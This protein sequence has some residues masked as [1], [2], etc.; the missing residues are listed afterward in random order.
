MHRMI[1]FWA[2]IHNTNIRGEIVRLFN[3]GNYFSNLLQSTLVFP[4]LN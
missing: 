4:I 2:V 3:M 1:E